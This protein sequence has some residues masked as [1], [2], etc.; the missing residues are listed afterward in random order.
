MLE[1]WPHIS[2]VTCTSSLQIP[3]LL[4]LSNRFIYYFLQT[5]EQ[6]CGLLQNCAG[7]LPSSNG[8]PGAAAPQ[9]PSWKILR[10][11]VSIGQNPYCSSTKHKQVAQV[12]FH[13][14][15]SRVRIIPQ[16]FPFT[17]DLVLSKTDFYPLP[18]IASALHGH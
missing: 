6:W 18:L 4:N 10:P 7:P 16:L 1:L 17:L 14:N 11:S 13:K 3:E 8:P 15:W 5:K 2:C 9:G 12:L